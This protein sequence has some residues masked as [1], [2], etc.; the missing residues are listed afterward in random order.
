LLTS[1]TKTSQLAGTALLAALV[2]VLDYAL[3]FSGLKIP[4]PWMPSLKFDF[5]GIPVAL[6]LLMYGLPS[7][8]TTSLV[9]FVAILVR[10]GDVVGASMKFVAEFSTVLGLALGLKLTKRFTS[11][12]QKGVGLVLGIAFRIIVMSLA[13]IIVLPNFYGITVAVAYGMIPLIAAFNVVSGAITILL[14][15]F[16]NEAVKRRFKTPPP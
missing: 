2:I 4:F 11:N 12:V 10:S 9:A 1:K 16:L 6:S 13:N 3:K 14:G 5:T 7:A 15:A 8:L